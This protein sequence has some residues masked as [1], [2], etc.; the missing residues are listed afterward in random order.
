MSVPSK[1]LCILVGDLPDG[2]QEIRTKQ[3]LA[4]SLA[5]EFHV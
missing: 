2:R 4:T 1:V 5:P 3:R